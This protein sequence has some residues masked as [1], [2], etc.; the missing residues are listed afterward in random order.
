RRWQHRRDQRRRLLR[1]RHR[2]TT[3]PDDHT[4]SPTPKRSRYE[5]YIH[6]EGSI[7]QTGTWQCL[8]QESVAKQRPSSRLPAI[9]TIDFHTL[10]L[11]CPVAPHE[12]ISPHPVENALIADPD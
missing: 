10:D 5:S 12:S 4:R 6:V 2:P 1:P 9:L 8:A 7:V 11:P 3:K